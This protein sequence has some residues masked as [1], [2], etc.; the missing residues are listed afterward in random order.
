MVLVETEPGRRPRSFP[1]ACWLA[2]TCLGATTAPAEVRLPGL[3][4][5]NMVLQSGMESPVWGWANS[6]E[7][8]TVEF[9]GQVATSRAGED[10]RWQ[11]N[12]NPL[13]P[14]TSA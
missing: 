2:W 5:D 14:S 7:S 11:V 1:F 12:L 3:F 10:S 9:A 13:A 8:I 4:S 6:G